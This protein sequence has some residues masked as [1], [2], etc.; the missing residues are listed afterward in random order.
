M[1]FNFFFVVYSRLC[2]KVRGIHSSASAEFLVVERPS[3]PVAA[4]WKRNCQSHKLVGALHWVP[5]GLARES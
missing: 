1:F 4:E 3:A 5:F 2:P